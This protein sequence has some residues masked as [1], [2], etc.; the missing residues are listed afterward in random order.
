MSS[1]DKRASTWDD[2]PDTVDRA[3]AIACKILQTLPIPSDARVLEFGAGTGLLSQYLAPQVGPLTL[4][5]PSSG[6]RAVI[7]AKVT[8]GQLPST[9]RVW[10]IDLGAQAPPAESFDLIVALMSMH[11]VHD[12]PQALR[13]FAE[14]LAPG[15]W[16]A[17][18][19]LMPE[20]GS[21]HGEGVDVHH[22]L[23]PQRLA[24]Q[25][26][27][28]GLVRSQ[29]QPDLREVDKDGGSYPLFLLTVAGAH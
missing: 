2:D 25:L 9:T 5:E 14:L 15:G 12:V 23:D 24:T 29:I 1:F 19:D 16:L 10:D 28:L 17:I 21:F 6:M 27:Q 3:R 13:A 18:V 22:G 8:Q 4:I 26:A 20:D 11:H 7:A